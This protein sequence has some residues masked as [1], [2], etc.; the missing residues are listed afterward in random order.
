M[1]NGRRSASMLGKHGCRQICLLSSRNTALV[2]PSFTEV[3]ISNL[4]GFVSMS[5]MFGLV[6]RGLLGRCRA[7]EG[8]KG[9]NLH[10][11]FLFSSNESQ[12]GLPILQY[13]SNEDSE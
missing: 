5:E 11:I 10:S 8:T 12:E 7:K 3:L 6:S 9:N 13:S 4:L 2:D 1:R